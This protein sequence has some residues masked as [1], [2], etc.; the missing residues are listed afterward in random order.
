[1]SRVRK[2]NR[3][4]RAALITAA[5]SA[6]RGKNSA[7]AARYRR[8]MRHRGHHKAVVAVAHTMLVTA[9]HLL[10][11]QATYQDLGASYLDQRYAQRLTK[12]AV[13]ALE[14]QGYRVTLERAA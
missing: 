7:L 11:R 13:R 10:V 1:V 5:L 14:G 9:Y 12:R 6:S 2:G 8:I 3:W 4:L